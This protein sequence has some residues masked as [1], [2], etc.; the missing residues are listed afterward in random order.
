MRI[1][2]HT[3]S[4]QQ[5]EIR[6]VAAPKLGPKHYLIKVLAVGLTSGEL[7]WRR[8]EDKASTGEHHTSCCGSRVDGPPGGPP[9]AAR[10]STKANIPLLGRMCPFPVSNTQ[11]SSFA[12]PRMAPLNRVRKYT[13]GYASPNKEQRQSTPP[14]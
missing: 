3:Q 5:L 14:P 1:V 9:H 7:W 8:P 13:C 6:T 4:T 12:D 2:Q 10:F 11:E